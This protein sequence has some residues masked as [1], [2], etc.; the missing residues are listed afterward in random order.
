MREPTM[1]DETKSMI[2]N[3]IVILQQKLVDAETGEQSDQIQRQIFALMGALQGDTDG[4]VVGGSI[5]HQ[6]E[7]Q[8][9]DETP[10]SV[11]TESVTYVEESEDMPIE[12]RLKEK[13][14]QLGVDE[15]FEVDEEAMYDVLVAL[16]SPDVRIAYIDEEDGLVIE[17]NDDDERELDVDGHIS[18]NG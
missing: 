18:S 2:L 6:V 9:I 17:Y 12:A 16:S 15:N 8:A 10:S 11:A 3:E 5:P 14:R 4:A 1:N 13:L 7:S